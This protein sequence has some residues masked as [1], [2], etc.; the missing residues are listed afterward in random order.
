MRKLRQSLFILIA[1]VSLSSC[2]TLFGG[3][4]TEYQKTRPAPGEPQRELRIG[5]LVADVLLF[6]PSLAVD[7][8]TGA[9]YKPK[10]ATTK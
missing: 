1:C 10:A 3:K 8:A 4:V 9:I 6:W 5:A 7:F 2:A